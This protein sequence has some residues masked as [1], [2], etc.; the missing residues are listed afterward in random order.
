MAQDAITGSTEL[1]KLFGDGGIVQFTETILAIGAL[2]L[3]ASALVDAS[4]VAGGGIARVGFPII[5][6]ALQ[7]YAA[8][9]KAV[10]GDDWPRLLEAHWINGRDKAEQKA[11]AVS[12][13]ML[14]LSPEIA[15]RLVNT[16][17][18]DPVALKTAL[19]NLRQGE[20]ALT[21]EDVSVIGRFRT[22]LDARI[23]A[24]FERAEQRYRNVAKAWAGVAAVA[25][26]VAATW[27]MHKTFDGGL[28]AEAMII[29]ALAVP[30]APIAKDLAGGL[31]AAARALKAG[32]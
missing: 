6:D 7:P 27:I 8:A 1:L 10:N 32:R 29:G 20:T 9:L 23:E 13:V 26:A 16:D 3:A 21:P 22:L 28:L 5:R 31:S 30:L 12:L 25:L 4:K 18:V 19:S 11:H 2:G 15:D 17:L 24:A 14:G